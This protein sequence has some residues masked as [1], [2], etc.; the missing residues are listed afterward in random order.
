MRDLIDIILFILFPVVI[1]STIV[2]VIYLIYIIGDML[3]ND[4]ISFLAFSSFWI[5]FLTYMGCRYIIRKYKKY[6]IY[7]KQGEY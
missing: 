2:S 3:I 5:I 7:K 1:V 4:T 6:K